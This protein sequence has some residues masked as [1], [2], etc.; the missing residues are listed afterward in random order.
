M[1]DEWSAGLLPEDADANDLPAP[2]VL[3]G[4]FLYE[5]RA[6]SPEAFTRYV[7][8]YDFGPTK[9]DFLVLHHTAVPSATWARFPTGAVWDTYE[10]SLSADAKIAKRLRQLESIRNY[11]RDRLGWDR[12]PHLFVDD[13][14]IYTF[15]PMSK[16]GIHA[17][18]GNSYSEHG[19]LHYSI[20]IEVVGCYK[21]VRWPARV[22]ANVAS[23]VCS[24]KATLG[25]FN[26]VSGPRAGQISEHRMFNKPSC[27]GDAVHPE[28]YLPYFQQ[29]WQ[30]G[31]PYILTD[32]ITPDCP[33]LSP[34]RATLDRAVRYVLERP[35][36][37]Y[38]DD[39]I[40][41]VI[42]PTYWT[43]CTSAG[44]D[45]VLAIAQLVHETGNLSS[46]W[47]ARPRRNPAG[48]GVTGRRS[49]APPTVGVWALRDGVW[50]EGLSFANWQ[51]EA[52]PA[53]VGRLLAYALSDLQ[54]NDAQRSL[55]VRALGWRPLPA[56]FRGVAPTLRGLNGRWAV[57]GTTY[58]NTIAKI[59]R[60]IAAV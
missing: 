5:G 12:G 16:I 46:W 26:F 55:I 38:T 40:G 18:Q 6:Y 59:A 39:D 51:A 3:D 25:T 4:E 52:I 30:H 32:T 60:A 21:S 28:W 53:H 57:P 31:P 14:A 43:L 15:T 10:A 8:S 2:V 44:L 41:N 29:A 50:H 33:L 54:A 35:H 9:P 56:S 1:S 22:L 49:D 45:P 19:W 7:Q 13:L 42:I 34:P 23:A 58:A 24:L 20:G 11:Y 48:L 37:E 36:G 47:S 17:A 27:P